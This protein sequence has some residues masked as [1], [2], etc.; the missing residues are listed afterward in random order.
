[1]SAGQPP[2]RAPGAPSSRWR[3]G[4]SGSRSDRPSRPSRTRGG[5]G[6]GRRAA[7]WRR[8]R[9]PA[10][11][12]GRGGPRGPTGP[13][14]PSART[15]TCGRCP[16]STRRRARRRRAA[17]IPGAWA[18]STSVS[19]PRRSSSA[20][21]SATGKMSAG[22]A[23]D[24]ADQRRAASAAVTAARIASSASAAGR[25]RERD[26]RDH[27]RAPSRAATAR[28]A[29]IVALYSW[30][31]VSSS[32]PGSKRSDC[33]TVLTPV[34]ALGTK[35][36]PVGIRAE[37]APTAARA[38]SSSP[39]RSSVRNCDRLGLEPVAPGPLDG[40]DRFRA[41]AVRAVVEERD[42]RVEPPAE[43]GVHA[44]SPRRRGSS[45]PSGDDRRRRRG[46]PASAPR[47]DRRRAMTV[48][49]R[50]AAA[51]SDHAGPL[52]QAERAEVAAAPTPR[53][54]RAEADP[55]WLRARGARTT[56]PGT[57]SRPAIPPPGVHVHEPSA[58][59]PALAPARTAPST[60][61][62]WIA[63]PAVGAE[64]DRRDEVRIATRE[65]DDVGLGE[66]R[67]SSGSAAL[68]ASTTSTARRLDGDPPRPPTR[69]KAATP[70]APARSGRPRAAAVGTTATR[71]GRLSP[72]RSTASREQRLEWLVAGLE[73]AAA[74]E[75]DRPSPG[76][77]TSPPVGPSGASRSSSAVA[78][79]RRRGPAGARRTIAGPAPAPSR[80]A[81]GT[82]PAGSGPGHRSG[83]AGSPATSRGPTGRPRR[84]RSSRLEN[85]A[86]CSRRAGS[87][88]E[89][90]RMRRSAE[91]EGT[92]C[93]RSRVQ[94]R[95]RW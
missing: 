5:T 67:H 65:V 3:P 1:M 21:S 52:R 64:H 72:T 62:R 68:A 82:G 84:A 20:T 78:A 88:D 77:L 69:S 11:G 51:P 17:T 74:V 76:R 33:R 15:A 57:T 28:I 45:R 25:D 90:S 55:G 47:P 31:L 8:A 18:P 4:A 36:R 9:R 50:S 89:T 35:A 94:H 75:R 61:A 6:S 24:V 40:E 7:R 53:T 2:P 27:D 14:C 37:E 44:G 54:A 39:G 49:C 91:G 58:I 63:R 83:P 85:P 92:R 16:S 23:R 86:S 48:G 30:S 12:S 66:P 38:S 42:R 87:R 56:R 59:A 79:G 34:V 95:L 19:I 13:R 93:G 71:I 43:V 81:R 73:L 29:L 46:P 22:R 26:R 70:F 80:T 10:D 32:S 60:R 41:G